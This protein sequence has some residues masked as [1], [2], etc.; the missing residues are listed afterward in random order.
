MVLVDFSGQR[1]DIDNMSKIEFNSD[2][3]VCN[4]FPYN[5]S[6]VQGEMEVSQE[7]YEK[8][9]SQPIYCAWRV[10][11]NVLELQQYEEKIWTADERLQERIKLHEATDDDFAKYSRQVRLN[12]DMPHSQQVLDYIDEYNLQVSDTVDQP[13]FPQEVT[14]PDYHLP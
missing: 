3:W 1:Q 7:D 6:D 10:L 4:R 11:N 5:F 2:G 8:T 9:L 14:Y 12:I 13:N